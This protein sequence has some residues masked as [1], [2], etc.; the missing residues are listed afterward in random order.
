VTLAEK[1]TMLPGRMA[2]LTDAEFPQDSDIKVP[3]WVIQKMRNLGLP[4]H[5]LVLGEVIAVGPRGK[6]TKSRSDVHPMGFAVGDRVAVM[7]LEGR[8][9][10]RND[11]DH[12][13]LSALI[14]E[15]K[16]LRL[17]G[18]LQDYSDQVLIKL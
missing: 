12:P 16:Q 14:P 8:I 3:D 2:V 10:H 17:Y 13:E 7:P 18:A 1:L 11:P 6:H 4:P 5:Q 9:I 15:G